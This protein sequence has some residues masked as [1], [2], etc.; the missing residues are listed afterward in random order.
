[1]LSE[2]NARLGKHSIDRFASALNTLL[3]WSSQE[4]H[5]V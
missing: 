5:D 3:P 1:M 2:L 4:G